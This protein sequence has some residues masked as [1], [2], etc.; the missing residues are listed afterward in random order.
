MSRMQNLT[1]SERFQTARLSR[2]ILSH[3]TSICSPLM[4]SFAEPVLQM[5][6]LT[7]ER[8]QMQDA[9]RMHGESEGAGLI[10]SALFRMHDQIIC[11]WILDLKQVSA[12]DCATKKNTVCLL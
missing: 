10:H 3:N 8:S 1:R 4:K 11:P 9:C 2:D 6:L 5:R 12:F 7:H